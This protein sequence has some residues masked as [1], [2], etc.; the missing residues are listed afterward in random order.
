MALPIF[1]TRRGSVRSSHAIDR[2]SVEAGL[3]IIPTTLFFLLVLQIVL[4]GSWQVV[5]RTRLHD[6]IIKSEIS[7]EEVVADSLGRSRITVEREEISGVGDLLRYVVESEIPVFSAL[8]ADGESK[9]VV[10]NRTIRID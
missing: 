10:R 7:G 2:G 9:L 8:S 3:A 4:A 1:T 5:E 6:L